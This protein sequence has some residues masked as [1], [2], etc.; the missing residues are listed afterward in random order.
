[1][2]SLPTIW[3]D[4]ELISRVMDNLIGNAFKYTGN[5]GTIDIGVEDKGAMLYFYVHDD[6]PGIPEEYHTRIF[7]KFVQVSNS[8]QMGLHKGIGLGLAFCRLAVEAHGGRIWVES[9]PP[10]GSTFIFI[11]PS[12]QPH[13][14]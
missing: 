1:V 5:G 8:G 7:D 13:P 12:Q 3:A 9:Q 2:D 10:E 11:L 14:E 6:G 4:A